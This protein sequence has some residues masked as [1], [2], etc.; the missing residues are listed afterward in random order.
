MIPCNTSPASEDYAD[1]I[2]RYSP[3]AVESLYELAG[4]TCVNLVSQEFAIVHVPLAGVLP[5]SLTRQT[6]SAIPKLY[7]LQDTTALESAG[8][9]PV[10]SQPNLASTGQ[11]VLIGLIDT[12]IDY[13][14]PLFR[15][16]DGTSRILS[17]WDQTREN[18]S[19]PPPV[20]G[21]Q[22]FFGTVYSQE[23][24]NRA[25]AAGDPFSIIPATD[26]NGHGTFL[27][28]VAAGNQASTL[29][30]FSGAAPDASLAVVRLKPAK[31]YL[32]DFFAVPADADAYQENDIMAAAAFLLGI[33][34]QY[35]MPL[36]LC[37]GAGTS[38]G[39][40]SGLSPL[41]MQLQALSGTRG[42]A[43]VT[44][45]GNETGFGRHYFSRLPA[46]QEFDDVELRIAAPGKDFSME[47]WADASELYT[48]GFVSPSG[49]VIERIPLAVGQETTLSF[50]L[51]ATRIFISYQLTEAGSG[52]F[53]AFL[54]FRGPAPGIWHIR[55][56]PALYVTGQ[57]HIWLPLQSF[58]PDDIR[59][60]RPDPDITITDP[61]NALCF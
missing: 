11:G 15:N 14:S 48:L 4:T 44:G 21:F 46:N 22:P 57:F 45:A 24:L 59:F 25:L 12:G 30:A 49:E 26:T 53:L 41:S 47:L 56:Y 7:G 31:Q 60:L 28:G 27:A 18:E 1:F 55:V 43:C 16:P 13:T 9:L 3:R 58:L 39:S 29:P 34:G 33:A 20:A 6:Y 54:R 32:R 17:I 23:D 8:I 10:F 50:R 19:L 38:Q 2:V 36:V 35:Q 52:R 61:G 5:L 40:H 42:F 51:D 37:L